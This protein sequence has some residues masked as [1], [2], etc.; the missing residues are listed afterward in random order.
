MHNDLSADRGSD[1]SR[2]ATFYACLAQGAASIELEFE[3]E[4]L[5]TTA[6]C[7]DSYCI[8]VILLRHETLS[9][10]AVASFISYG[11]FFLKFI[12]YFCFFIYLFL[13]FFS[14]L[15]L[16][17]DTEEETRVTCLFVSLV[18]CRLLLTSLP[19]LLGLPSLSLSVCRSTCCVYF[20]LIAFFPTFINCFSTLY[21]VCHV[22]IRWKS[23]IIPCK[24]L[25]IVVGNSKSPDL[26]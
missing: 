3:L 20:Y 2:F 4:I 25:E 18:G 26:A 9:A 23:T 6:P 16:F 11:F 13:F 12:F 17:I 14:S 19:P 22:R 24:L 1:T 7:C 10:E 5:S 15:C 21:S 8:I